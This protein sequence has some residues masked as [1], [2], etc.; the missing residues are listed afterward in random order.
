MKLQQ[1]RKI[2]LKEAIAEIENPYPKDD[3]IRSYDD[4]LEVGLSLLH[5]KSNP[6]VLH[7]LCEITNELWSTPKRVNRQKL[8]YLIKKYINNFSAD[9]IW[10]HNAKVARPA[11]DLPSETCKLLF[12]LFKKACMESQYLPKSQVEQAQKSA[13]NFL[14]NIGLSHEEEQWLC[15][16]AFINKNFL[17][18]VMRYPVRSKVMTQ[19]AMDNYNNDALRERR[20]ELLSWIINEDP[21]YEISVKTIIDDFEYLYEKDTTALRDFEHEQISSMIIKHELGDFVS[22]NNQD[23]IMAPD[24]N[25]RYNITYHGLEISNRPYPFPKDESKDFWPLHMPDFKQLKIDFYNNLSVHQQFTMIWAIA[26]CKLD[27]SI[28]FELL[29]KYLNEKTFKSMY[30]VGIKNNNSQLLKWMLEEVNKGSVN[31][32][33]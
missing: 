26:Y 7:N 32:D 5:Y 29:K 2:K 33:R 11:L 1:Y 17:N 8:L 21:N 4:F 25:G 12:Q 22:L 27:N 28:K 31:K 15:A 20:S 16:H 10:G 30:R 14:I 19:W 6:V 9:K 18:R 23:E 24:E 13:N 3:L